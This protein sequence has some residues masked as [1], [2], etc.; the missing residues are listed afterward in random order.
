MDIYFC[1]IFKISKELK[2]TTE[3]LKKTSP[4]KHTANH[5]CYMYKLYTHWHFQN[6]ESSATGVNVLQNAGVEYKLNF[7]PVL[8]EKLVLLPNALRMNNQLHRYLEKS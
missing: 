2:S 8:V 4:L 7:V 5:S 6:G 1:K 3:N